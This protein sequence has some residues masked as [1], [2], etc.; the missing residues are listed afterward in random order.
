MIKEDFELPDRLVT[1][2]FNTLF[3][4]SAHR[5]YIKIR[6]AHGHQSWTW[7][8]TQIINKWENDAWRFKV[9]TTFESEKFNSD[10]DK[11]LPWSFQQK[12]RL[13]A[14]YPDMSESMIHRKTL[15]Q[16]GGDPQ[17]SVKS[18]TTK[19]YLVL[20][21]RI[22]K[23]GLINL[24]K[25]LW[26]K[27]P[28]KIL[29]ISNINLQI[30]SGN[31]I[32]SKE[33]HICPIHLQ[34]SGKINEINT[35]K[36]P[37]VEK[38]VVIEE[39]YDD[40][41]LIFSESSRYIED[42]MPP[43]QSYA[44]L[45]KTKPN[46]RKGYTAGNSCITE[47]V[48][49]NKPTKLLLDPGA[50]CSCVGRSFLKT[51]VPNFEH[52][53]LPIDAIKFNSASNPIKALVIFETSVIFP[54]RN[55]NLR[56]T[57]EF[58]VIE[59]WSSTHFIL[60]NDYLI[61]YVLDKDRYFTIGNN[62]CKKFSFLPFKR[63]ITV[64][65]VSPVNLELKKFKSEQLNEAEIS[66]HLS[67]E[68]ENELSA[69]S[70]DHTEALASDKEPLEEIIAHEVEITLNIERPYPPLVRRPTHPESPKSRDSL[71]I[72]LTELL[73]ISLV[74]KVGHNEEVEIATP[75]IVAWHS[76]N[77]RMVGDFRALST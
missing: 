67:D 27:N 76:R 45:M 12:D 26:T 73:D 7:W 59:N 38:D 8:K 75:A 55:G 57:F 32:F 63:Q 47:V 53:L 3:T 49:D 2:R 1:A 69:L 42:T 61:I 35:E 72:H 21:G 58:V 36:E 64:N 18:R 39:N 24:G 66:L 15:R 25:I 48:I 60:G 28:K 16:G 11:A 70:Y 19:Q 17:H 23:Q 22:S 62:N 40:K 51:C 34:K 65:E 6:Q 14:L 54:H 77:S 13:P 20:V 5:W 68:Q 37:D 71:E 74:R 43:L 4:K 44:Q 30:Q 41:T 56:I 50:F 10:K 29:I 33:P 46:S 31:A 9:E 52:K